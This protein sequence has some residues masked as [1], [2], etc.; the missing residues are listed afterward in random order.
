MSAFTQ[1]TVWVIYNKWNTTWDFV[2]TKHEKWI[3]SINH[4]QMIFKP[5]LLKII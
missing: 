5:A 1:N 4:N 3:E 2:P